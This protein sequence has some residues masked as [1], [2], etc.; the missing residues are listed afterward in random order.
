MHCLAGPAQLSGDKAERLSRGM[1]LDEALIVLRSSN[2][3][4]VSGHL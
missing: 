2:S 3:V 4:T 1:K